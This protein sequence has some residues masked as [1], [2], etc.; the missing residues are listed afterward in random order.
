MK[1]LNKVCLIGWVNTKPEISILQN[2]KKIAVFYLDTF[3]AWDDRNLGYAKNRLDRYKITIF[4]ES[5]IKIAE[6]Y[7]KQGDKLY[8][9]GNLRIRKMNTSS[10]FTKI[11]VDVI[12]R[13]YRA[14]LIF[15]DDKVSK[16]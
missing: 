16:R 3:E 9:E 14:N 8:I 5:L 4:Q 12:L 7:I 10:N 1:T 15:M 2:D 6:C 11:D 13:G